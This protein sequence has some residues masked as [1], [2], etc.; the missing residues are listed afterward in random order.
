MHLFDSHLTTPDSERQPSDSHLYS[1]LTAASMTS[2]TPAVADPARLRPFRAHQ[3]G[4]SRHPQC[5]PSSAKASFHDFFIKMA[6]RALRIVAAS[7]PPQ[8]RRAT[9]V[10]R[11]RFHG[12]SL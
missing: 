12:Y 1:R 8:H 9:D 6:L 11:G 2:W 3:G 7:L 10:K 4:K 5:V